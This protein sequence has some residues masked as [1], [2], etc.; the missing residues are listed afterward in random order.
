MKNKLCRI[1]G[2]EL[3]SENWYPSSQKTRNY[4]CKKCDKKRSNLWAKENPEKSRAISIRWVRKQG[5]RPFSEN[6][7]CALYLGVH[8][9][10]RVLSHV[11]KDVERMPYANKGFDFIC[12]R[13]KKIDVKSACLYKSIK[14]CSWGF[15]INHNTT[16]DYFLCLA[17]DSRENLNPMY[18][19]MIPGNKVNYLVGLAIRTT[20]LQKWDKYRIDLSKISACCDIMRGD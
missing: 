20:T 2:I 13:G 17:F 8:V 3:D 10:E 15:Q 14:G 19:W 16:A 1:C 4:I 6:R 11:F 12:N 18:V 9:A 7:E 5:Q